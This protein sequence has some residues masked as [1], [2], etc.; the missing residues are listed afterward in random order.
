MLRKCVLKMYCGVLF[1]GWL[2]GKYFIVGEGVVEC[3]ICFIK[4]DDCCYWYSKVL[5]RNCS[6]F[7]VYRFG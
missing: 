3:M 6:D 5:V 1:F 7:I 2:N 4:D